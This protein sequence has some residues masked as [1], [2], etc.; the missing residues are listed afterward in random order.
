MAP[1]QDLITADDEEA[2]AERAAIMEHDG[3][4]S[5]EAAEAAA[6]RAFSIV[7]HFELALIKTDP[8][9]QSRVSI[10]DATVDDYAEVLQDGAADLPAVMLFHDGTDHWLADG[11]HRVAAYRKRSRTTIPAKLHS[12]TPRDAI[13]Y[14]AGANAAHGLRRSNEDKR[15]AG[16]LLLGDPEWSKWSDNAIGKHVGVDHKTVARWRSEHL[17]NSQHTRTR[18]V[19]RNGTTYEQDTSNIG[20]KPKKPAS[21]PPSPPTAPEPGGN[22][23]TP[24]SLPP[25]EGGAAA[26][27]PPE[28]TTAADAHGAD[29]TIETLLEETAAELAAA[30]ELLEVAAA[31]DLKAEAIKWKKSADIARRERDDVQAKLVKREAEIKRYVTILKRIGKAVG[32]EDQWKV[33]GR[34]E[35]L[36]KNATVT[37]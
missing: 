34:V 6:H 26:P 36:V 17:G 22:S 10:N 23:S 35:L 9:M 29:T 1:I 13:L 32:E 18:F 7:T 8:R 14:A 16:G 15:K 30:Q 19:E 2:F 12:G 25:T 37:A 4:M 28:D 27:I 5:A 31:D 24:P 3:G 11:W 33:A 21:P 20:K